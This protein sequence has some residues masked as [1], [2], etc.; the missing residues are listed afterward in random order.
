MPEAED[1]FQALVLVIWPFHELAT[2][3]LF[4]AT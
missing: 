2:T 1:L 3:E 4:E